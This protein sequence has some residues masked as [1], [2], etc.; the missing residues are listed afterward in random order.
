MSLKSK[1]SSVVGLTSFTQKRNIIVPRKRAFIPRPQIPLFHKKDKVMRGSNKK[2]TTSNILHT[3]VRD[4]KRNQINNMLPSNSAE[5]IRKQTSN[6][7]TVVKNAGQQQDEHKIVS[8]NHAVLD[9]GASTN[10]PAL[11]ENGG[12]EPQQQ[13]AHKVKVSLKKLTQTLKDIIGKVCTS[14][15]DEDLNIRKRSVLSEFY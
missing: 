3:K 15:S 2:T 12:E 1:K 6:E 10:K 11:S 13:D 8:S 5:D 7:E 4:R 9:G 14:N